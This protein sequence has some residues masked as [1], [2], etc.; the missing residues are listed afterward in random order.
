[1]KNGGQ[2]AK[3][4]DVQRTKKNARQA[5]PSA[6]NQRSVRKKGR[7]GQRGGREVLNMIC[8]IPSKKVKHKVFNMFIYGEVYIESN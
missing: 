7:V 6:F 2:R 8:S 1:M 5:K 4:R 3:A